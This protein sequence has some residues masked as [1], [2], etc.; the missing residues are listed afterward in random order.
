MEQSTSPLYILFPV[1]LLSL[2]LL[3]TFGLYQ[4]GLSGPFLFDDS[5]NILQNTSVHL[6]RLSFE[7]LKLAA[8]G[9]THKGDFMRG[10][11]MVSFALNHYWT[12]LDARPFKVTNLIIHL[13]NG[14]LVFYLCQLWLMALNLRHDTIPK[15][16]IVW[17]SLAVATVW[18][19]HPINVTSVLYVVQR[20]TSLASL[21]SLLGMIAYTWGRINIYQNNRQGWWGIGLA[22]LCLLLAFFSKENGGLLVFYLSLIEWLLFQFHLPTP[23]SRRR[24]L[25]AAGLLVILPLLAG[26]I[27]TFLRWDDLM[28]AYS[29][30]AFTPEQRL[31]TEA[32]VLWLYL[33]WILLPRYQS[34]GLYHDDIPFSST[35]LDPWTTLPA[36]FAWLGVV[37]FAFVWRQRLPVLAFSVAF[38]LAAHSMEASILPLELVHEHRNYLPGVAILFGVI[39]YA[40]K[41][42]W[43]FKK[44]PIVVIAV[45]LFSLGAASVTLIRS[46]G[47]ADI[48]GFFHTAVQHHPNSARSHY[49][50]G[51]IYVLLTNTTQDKKQIEIYWDSAISQFRQAADLEPNEKGGILLATLI[52]KA[53]LGRLPEIT[54]VQEIKRSLT[55]DLPN[56]LIVLNWVALIECHLQHRCHFPASLIHELLAAAM[57]NP[58]LLDKDKAKILAPMTEYSLAASNMT[59]ALSYAQKAIKADP[60]HPQHHLNL[61]LLLIYAGDFSAAQKAIGEA[62]AHD[63]LNTYETRRREIEQELQRVQANNQ[64]VLPQDKP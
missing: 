48:L 51:R 38:F 28:A 9:Y 8:S 54:E 43:H 18:L 6:K 40:D 60:E 49:E 19:V 25:Q 35:W 59:E 20:M 32:R 13:V 55:H 2:A 37:G 30:R 45:L 24:F 42:P 56:S 5:A 12:G 14:I 36:V 44:I 10:I 3:A 61:A 63:T 50:L 11:S 57:E 21:F 64:Q 22:I 39:Y 7:Q 4:G 47:L 53:T 16:K 23:Q 27:F 26:A 1:A 17:L 58:K 33:Q 15:T 29:Y 52:G 46:Q 31:L 34:Y 41:I 62:L